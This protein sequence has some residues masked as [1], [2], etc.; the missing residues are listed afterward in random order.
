MQG[1]TWLS[2]LTQQT[3]ANAKVHKLIKSHLVTHL[4]KPAD[5]RV[6]NNTTQTYC[7]YGLRCFL[8]LRLYKTNSLLELHEFASSQSA[9]SKSLS[10]RSTQLHKAPFPPAVI[11]E[12]TFPTSVR[13]SHT[14]LCALRH[15]VFLRHIKI[16]YAAGCHK[17]WPPLH[18]NIQVLLNFQ[19]KISL[20]GT[21]SV[22]LCWWLT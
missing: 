7:R 22:E 5:A 6:E 3:V 16:W 19:S 2:L 8:I 14:S 18:S 12:I 13:S 17:V 21:S 1:N 15:T 9:D 11:Q 4:T 10:Q 20:I